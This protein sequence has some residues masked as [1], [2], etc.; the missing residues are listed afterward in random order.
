MFC[1]GEGENTD[2]WETRQAH[3]GRLDLAWSMEGL[4]R[5]RGGEARNNCM[6]KEEK[7]L[8]GGLRIL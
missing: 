7:F 8:T 1:M 6:F 4:G 2:K 3:R 5:G